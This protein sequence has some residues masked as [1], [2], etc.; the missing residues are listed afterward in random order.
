MKKLKMNGVLLIIPIFTLIASIGYLSS[1][2]CATYNNCLPNPSII[3]SIFPSWEPSA[4]PSSTPEPSETPTPTS[5]PSPTAEPTVE[6]SA[7]PTPT[8]EPVATPSPTVAPSPQ[9]LTPAGGTG[10]ADI[11]TES[12]TT[13]LPINTH[14]WR[15]GDMA[16]VEWQKTEG[17]LVD[18]YYKNVTSPIWQH[19]KPNQPNNGYAEVHGLGNG[20]FTFAVMQKNGCGGGVITKANTVVDGPTTQWVWFGPIER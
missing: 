13:L 20:D 1:P 4:S 2:A 18:I 15:K 9:G 8:R 10:S 19:S 5:E 16:K 6:P 17:N 7:T 14:V 11:C 12:P 3:P